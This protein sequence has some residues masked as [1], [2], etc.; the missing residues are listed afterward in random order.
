M[1]R[2]D[3]VIVG[4]ALLSV[5]PIVLALEGPI[6]MP[7]RYDGRFWAGSLDD[8]LDHIATDPSGFRRIGLVWVPTLG[9]VVAGMTAFTHQVSAAG[10]ATWP[11]LAFG[12]YTVAA[13]AWFVGVVVQT[14]VVGHAA[15]VRAASGRTPE[16]LPGLWSVGWWCEVTFVV[17]GN[18]A[19]A[20][21]GIGMLQ[22]GYPARW[23]GWTAIALA[24]VV[25]G[26]AAAMRS[27][28]PHLGIA[29]PLVLGVALLVS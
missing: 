9:I 16:W 21:W 3:S 15:E 28:F 13:M 7:G 10:S 20:L 19:A 29:M 14:S 26:A 23:M 27:V 17:A 4:I 1:N 2:T 18:V 12:L 5:L 25:L 22:A 8:K 24:A 6:S 11:W